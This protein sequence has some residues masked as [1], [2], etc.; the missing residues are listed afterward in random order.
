[1]PTSA[2]T[3][4]S[5]FVGQTVFVRGVWTETSLM[6]TSSG[7]NSWSFFLQN[8]LATDDDNALTSDGITVYTGSYADFGYLN[9][10]GY[11]EPVVGEEVVIRARVSEYYGLTELGS[12]KLV[13]VIRDGVDLSTEIAQVAVNPPHD[14]AASPATGSVSSRCMCTCRP[15]PRSWRDATSSPARPTARCGSSAATTR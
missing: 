7:Y 8:T 2:D 9:Q 5:P 11:Y 14:L 10:P 3:Q 12:A 4:S 15:M 6:R 1:M 13:S